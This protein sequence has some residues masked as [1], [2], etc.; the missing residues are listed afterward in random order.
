MDDAMPRTDQTSKLLIQFLLVTFLM[1]APSPT[2]AGGCCIQYEGII[3]CGCS[4]SMPNGQSCCSPP[5]CE[6]V[7]ETSL[8]D[9]FDI[10][11]KLDRL[12]QYATVRADE[13]QLISSEGRDYWFR[14]KWT[15]DRKEAISISLERVYHILGLD[16]RLLEEKASLP[17]LPGGK[18]LREAR[19]LGPL[20]VQHLTLREVT[21]GG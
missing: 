7:P 10:Q 14:I 9:L 8:V 21:Q 16:I 19:R 15:S 3:I 20:T 11:F 1:A 17:L 5:C 2:F 4:V 6:W 12:E 13:Q 18:F